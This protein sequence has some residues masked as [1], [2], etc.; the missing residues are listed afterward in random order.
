MPLHDYKCSKCG[1]TSEE[2]VRWDEYTRKCPKC[3]GISDRVYISFNGIKHTAP[4]WL[5][6]VTEVVDKDGGM[7]C[8]EFLKHQ[9]RSTY[10]NWMKTEGLR[11]ME[12]GESMKRDKTNTSSIRKAVK[13]KFK[14]DNTIAIGG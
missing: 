13:D 12:P 2:V 10:E 3:N 6:S 8:Q 14:Q 9:D 5:K 7:H 11:P 4:D 1:Y